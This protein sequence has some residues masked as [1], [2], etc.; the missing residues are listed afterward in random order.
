MKKYI[1]YISFT[2]ILLLLCIST[3][4][5]ASTGSTVFI[6]EPVILNDYNNIEITHNKV[7]IN[8]ETSEI[9]NM[10]LFTNLS[11]EKIVKKASIKLEDSYS[12]LTINSLKIKVNDIEIEN[13]EKIEDEYIFYFEIL[14]KEGK[15]IEISYKTDSDLQNAKI[16]K[17]SMDKLKGKDVKLFQI[18]VKLSKYDI[19]LV[20]KIW[21]GAYEYD[22]ENNIVST[23]YFDFKVNNLTSQFIIEKET[24]KN[25]KYGTN[26]E[27][28]N[29]I[30]ETFLT[31]IKE[32][33]DGKHAEF[34]YYNDSKGIDYQ[35]TITHWVYGRN[36]DYKTDKISTT[37]ERLITYT[38]LIEAYNNNALIYTDSERENLAILYEDYGDDFCLASLIWKTYTKDYRFSSEY[39]KENSAV[40]KKAAIYYYETEQGKDL[41]VNKDTTNNTHSVETPKEAFVLTKRDEYSILRTIVANG[42]PNSENNKGMKRVYVNSDIDGNKIDITEEEIIQFVNMMNI[43]LFIRIVLYDPSEEYPEVRVGYYTN[44]AKIIA[45]EYNS[46]EESINYYKKYIEELQEYG[47]YFGRKQTEEEIKEK[48]TEYNS[49]IDRINKQI[50][51]FHNDVVEKNCKIPVVAHCVGICTKEDGKYVIEFN[52]SGDESGL[53][54][55]YGA[56]ECEVAKRMLE[57]N[58]KTN[59]AKINEIVNKITST[60]VTSDTVEEKNNKEETITNENN[61]LIPENNTQQIETKENNYSVINYITKSP[62]VLGSIII[63]FVLIIVLISFI[64]IRKTKEKKNGREQE[65]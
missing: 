49:A 21:P 45:S 2:F 11:N 41:Y 52:N 39:S 31:H 17:Y 42:N 19:P 62:I 48:M 18:N 40:G 4:S 24:Y 64:I 26:S 61:T 16:I 20:Q 30:E 32:Y 5:E 22:F 27:E 51:Q 28:L 60:K 1:I 9:S 10:Q 57:E 44:E 14:P 33:M 43:D 15:R 54:Y 50:K 8:E 46:S 59:D 13:F 65:K 58:K 47:T 63:I 3:N 12:S 36:W 29:E 7:D 6:G 55:I 35:N 37:I 53:G 23:E 25:L 34:V 38:F 56:S